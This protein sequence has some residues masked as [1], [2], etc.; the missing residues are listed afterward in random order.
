PS[1]WFGS[2]IWTA[3]ELSWLNSKGKPQVALGRFEFAHTSPHLIESKSLKLYLNSLN[4]ESFASVDAYQAT[5]QRDLSQAAG[6]TVNVQI[7]PLSQ[8]ETLPVAPLS[9]HCIDALDIAIDRY[10]PAP[11]LL[12]CVPG[13]A[14]VTETLVS[15][16]LKSN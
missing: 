3:Y 13:A 15:N 5:V 2:D 14:P 10:E 8:A 16:L 7:T 12:A 6:D 1:P 4:E 11:D 9:G